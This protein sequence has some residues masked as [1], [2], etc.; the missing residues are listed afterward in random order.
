MNSD[1]VLGVIV[2]ICIG[3]FLFFLLL[4]NKSGN[5]GTDTSQK[6]TNESTKDSIG[7]GELIGAMKPPD[8]TTDEVQIIHHS[9]KSST[10]VESNNEKHVNDVGNNLSTQE[11]EDLIDDEKMS[12]LKIESHNS[13]NQL[14]VSSIDRSST[15]LQNQ[16]KDVQVPEVRRVDREAAS[17]MSNGKNID[18]NSDNNTWRCACE[19]G[20][21]PPGLLKSFSGVEAMVRMGTGQCYHKT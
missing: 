5:I 21:L 6:D 10:S 3:I 15:D 12:V 11:K 16:V 9:P 14:N 4:H 2:T 17:I 19:S 1:E 18:S 13:M 7:N 20:F 8:D